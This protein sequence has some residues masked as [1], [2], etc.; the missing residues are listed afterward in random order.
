MRAEKEIRK[1]SH[2]EKL[3]SYFKAEIPVLVTVSLTGILYNIGMLAGPWF[4][5][6]MV[7]CLYDILNGNK[8]FADMVKIAVSYVLVILFVQGMRA[9]KRFYVRRFANDTAQNMRHMLYNSLIWETGTDTES[10]SAGSIMTKSISDVDACTEGMRKFTTELFDTGVVLVSYL[11]MLFWYDARLT[12]IA[13]VFTP[14]AYFTAGFLKKKVFRA[15]TAYRESTSN[16]NNALLDRIGAALTYRVYGRETERNDALE[17][18]LT[19]YER[20]SVSAGLWENSLQPLYKIISMTGVIFIIVFGARNL[21]GTGWA[22]WNLAAFTT[23]LSCFSKMAAKSSHAARLFNSVQKAEISWKRIRPIMKEYRTEDKKTTLD[24]SQPVSVSAENLSV[25]LPG[26]QPLFT[27]LSFDAKPGDIIGITGPVASGKSVFGKIFLA[28]YPYSGSLRIE[29][30]ELRN[31]TGY[32]RS[33]LI[34]YQGHSPELLTAS[35]G[36]NILLG[37]NEDPS[38]YLKEVCLD[39]E[40]SQMPA[41]IQTGV[42]KNGVRLSGGQEAR[43]ALAR[44]LCQGQKI[45]VLDD[46]FSA[47]DIPVEKKIFENLRTENPDRIIFLISHRLSLFPETDKIIWIGSGKSETGAHAEM[48]RKNPEYRQLFLSQTEKG[49]TDEK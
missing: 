21:S 11:G 24:F 8:V 4:E 31:L 36:E 46:P 6:R 25:S 45:L 37:K 23:Y 10:E 40:V 35:I 17:K 32:E 42:G 22:S 7:Q 49:G 30:R 44:A 38:R 3:G 16:L 14:A 47:V 15:N 34:A 1:I 33:R 28:E 5:G 19:D 9:L 43:T 39:G 41:G 48:L 18:K 29:N 13:I 20:K 2:P 26:M 12:L 27:D